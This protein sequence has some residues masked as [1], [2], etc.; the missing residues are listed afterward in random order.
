MRRIVVAGLLLAAALAS[1]AAAVGAVQ[2]REPSAVTATPWTNK[3][4]LLSGKTDYDLP[5]EAGFI[6]LIPVAGVDVDAALQRAG[7]AS[8]TV[9]GST[10]VP[11]PLSGQ[12]VRIY[13]VSVPPGREKAIVTQLAADAAH[14][15]FVG[16]YWI[17]PLRG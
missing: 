10:S 3:Q 17:D 14:F 16:L 8:A 13:R 5:F 15:S 11:D 12:T 6:Q 9:V 4:P 2:R 7:L 1:T